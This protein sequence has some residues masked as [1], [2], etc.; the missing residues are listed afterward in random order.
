MRHLLLLLLSLWS[1]SSLQGQSLHSQVQDYLKRNNVP[2][3]FD[4][5]SINVNNKSGYFFTNKKGQTT[6]SLPKGAID[7]SVPAGDSAVYIKIASPKF[8]NDLNGVLIISEY[9]DGK[10]IDEKQFG[11][12]KIRGSVGVRI[13][14]AIDNKEIPSLSLYFING[15]IFNYQLEKQMGNLIDA[16]ELNKGTKQIAIDRPI[17]LWLLFEDKSKDVTKQELEQWTKQMEGKRLMQKIAQEIEH[18]YVISYQ[19]NNL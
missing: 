8:A 13:D 12:G 10:I 6:L 19:L 5:D 2:H 17:H 15:Q 14:A 3:Y 18:Y 4:K 11:I 16:L 1:V 9:R 7:L